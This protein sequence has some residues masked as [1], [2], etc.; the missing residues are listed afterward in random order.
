MVATQH[1][2][3]PAAYDILEKG[4]L[5]ASGGNFCI[6]QHENSVYTLVYD[7]KFATDDNAHAGWKIQHVEQIK[8]ESKP[9]TFADL[10]GLFAADSFFGRT[11]EQ[12]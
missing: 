7:N 4:T 10:K 1:N 11:D 8:K 2:P 12:T 5:L 9:V 3:H 6:M